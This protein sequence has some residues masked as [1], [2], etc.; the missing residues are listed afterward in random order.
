MRIEYDNGY[1]EGDVVDGKKHGKGVWCFND[2]RRY[3]GEFVNDKIQGKGVFY[4]SLGHTYMGT[5]SDY[6]NGKGAIMFITKNH[7]FGEWVDFKMQGKGTYFFRGGDKYIG[8]FNDG[9]IDGNGT[10]WFRN[11][12]TYT[13]QV[14]EK[15]LK[16]KGTMIFANG[17][18]YEGRWSFDKMN[19][20]GTFYFNDGRKLEG[21]FKLNTFIDGVLFLQNNQSILWQNLSADEQ[22]T[23]NKRLKANFDANI[24]NTP[25]GKIKILVNDKEVKYK[26][27]KCIF[28]CGE[29]T[30]Y[31]YKLSYKG[32][33]TGNIECKIDINQ[34]VK[35]YNSE[36]K[37]ATIKS[38]EKD[39]FYLELC[40][41]DI[42]NNV[43]HTTNDGLMLLN[44]PEQTLNKIEFVV[45]WC[46]DFNG[47]G[48]Q[49]VF[50]TIKRVIELE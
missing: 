5:W 10:V 19:G 36:Y 29:Q 2:G 30:M 49:M 7:Y 31:C 28:E 6:G 8:D 9:E 35:T 43:C 33:I 4:Y 38:F 40:G 18:K 21:K 26:F 11:G 32:N 39:N 12:N 27:E 17:D 3:S 50:E 34:D 45:A 37:T 20:K 14:K 1:Y 15:E 22:A 25:F 44:I 42:D 13:G 23:I 48:D 46:T 16:G 41:L 24:I 47:D